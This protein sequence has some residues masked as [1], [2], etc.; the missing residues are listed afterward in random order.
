MHSTGSVPH[1]ASKKKFYVVWNGK[2]PGVFATWEECNSSIQGHPNAKYKSFP[3][4]ESAEKA[5]REG[6]DGYWGTGKFV[7][8]LS[9]EQ[10]ALVG[11]PIAVLTVLARSAI[12]FR[13]GYGFGTPVVTVD[14]SPTI[15][16][17]LQLNISVPTR[18]TGTVHLKACLKCEAKDTRLFNLSEENPP[19]VL[20]EQNRL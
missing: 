15:G 1:M 10:L 20:L 17:P 12:Q 8:G 3:T 2:K 19:K 5:F 7:S 14:R 18:F 9:D 4:L 6:S 13:R 11:Q 16:Q